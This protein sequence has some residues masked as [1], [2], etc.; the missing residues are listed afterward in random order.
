MASLVAV[1]SVACSSSKSSSSAVASTG[2][3]SAACHQLGA[4]IKSTGT[5]VTA[6]GKTL[7]AGGQPDVKPLQEDD[8]N[9]HLLVTSNPG[10]FAAE[11]G[12]LADVLGRLVVDIQ[13]AP[14]KIAGDVNQFTPALKSAASYCKITLG[15]T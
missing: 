8:D 5:A 12:P 10:A 11:V 13:D 7:S 1:G 3:K 2:S 4:D 14:S 9:L 6:V 15:P